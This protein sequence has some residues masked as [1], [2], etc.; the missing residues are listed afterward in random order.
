MRITQEADYAIRIVSLLSGSDTVRGAADIAEETGVP[1]RFTHKI[2]RKLLQGGVL[3][4]FSGAHGGYMLHRSPTSITLLDIIELIDG[5]FAL[6]KC[7]DETYICS[8]NGL[9]KQGCV[10]HCVFAALSSMVSERLQRMSIAE[11]NDPQT[12]VNDVITRLQ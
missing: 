5:P 6:S 4:S 3:R 10:Y 12:N 9:C 1:Q 7:A 2:L 8:K 11:L